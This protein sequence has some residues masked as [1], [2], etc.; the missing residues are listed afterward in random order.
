LRVA[1]VAIDM[2]ARG[3]DLAREDVEEAIR[4]ETGRPRDAEPVAD[5][6]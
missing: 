2:I 3:Y 1:W 5:A 6:Q 4:F